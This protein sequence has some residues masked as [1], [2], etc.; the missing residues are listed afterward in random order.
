MY[1]NKIKLELFKSRISLILGSLGLEFFQQIVDALH[2]VGCTVSYPY[3]HLQIFQ[4]TT[5]QNGLQM[6]RQQKLAKLQRPWITPITNLSCSS[7]SLT[8]HKYVVVLRK[9][10]FSHLQSSLK[11]KILGNQPT[12]KQNWNMNMRTV[13][14]LIDLSVCYVSINIVASFMNLFFHLFIC[15]R[16]ERKARDCKL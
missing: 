5:N 9:L 12:T 6:F 2:R 10:S 1:Q 11:S 8:D 13:Y 15:I 3:T 14:L 16:D 7:F 4:R